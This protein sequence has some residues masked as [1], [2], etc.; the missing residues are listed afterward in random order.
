MLIF[1]DNAL[2]SADRARKTSRR[3]DRRAENFFRGAIYQLSRFEKDFRSSS[4]DS[5][6]NRTVTR[7]AKMIDKSKSI[8]DA[9]KESSHDAK[10]KFPSVPLPLNADE[11]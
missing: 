11:S 8:L 2:K 7:E 5:D 3:L 1:A 6:G 4:K 9:F 10:V